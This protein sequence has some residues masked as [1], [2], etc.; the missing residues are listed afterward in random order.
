ML[1]EDPLN[2][3]KL[4]LQEGGLFSLLLACCLAYGVL[5]SLL[6][7]VTFSEDDAHVMR[8]AL[9]SGWLSPYFDGASYKQ[10]SAANFTPVVLTLFRLI[11]T[12]LPFSD[13]SFLAVSTGMLCLFTALAG[14]LIQRISQSQLAGWLA[15]LIIFSNLAVAT[16]VSRFYTLHYTAGGVFALL[17]IWLSLSSPLSIKRLAGISSLLTI[18]ILAKEVYVVVPPLLILF[19]WRNKNFNLSI[20]ALISLGM[21]FVLR[22]TVLGLPSGGG[23]SSYLQS[24]LF[25]SFD[26]WGYNFLAWYGQSKWLILI[27]AF[28]AMLLAPK[29]FLSLLPIPVLFLLPTFLASHGY[30]DPHMHGDRIFF[31]FDSS[32]AMISAFAI[33]PTLSKIPIATVAG[34]VVTLLI[35]VVLQYRSIQDYKASELITADYKV[36]KFLTGLDNDRAGKTFY[37]PLSFE[38]GQL[39]KVRQLLNLS[40]YSVTQNCIMALQQPLDQLT[41]FDQS[42]ILS[43]RSELEENCVST[44]SPVSPRQLPRAIR[45]LVEWDLQVDA[46]FVGG[47]IFVDRA[48]AVPAPSF[49]TVMLTP[50][51]GERYQLFAFKGKQWWFSEIAQMEIQR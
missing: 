21:Y 19:G 5:V 42:G 14:I 3:L 17:S 16:L 39:V 27:I 48:I 20:A 1:L 22:F 38:Q 6:S 50:A 2:K 33:A 31:A 40:T 44:D 13:S 9:E 51:A 26:S 43:S 4:N 36:T 35:T 47:V 49:S 10:L 23:D 30:L 37:V 45:G 28:A 18:S 7:W 41:V 29:R 11:M 46:G 32:L 24:I 25:V 34:L 8:V 12:L 15:A